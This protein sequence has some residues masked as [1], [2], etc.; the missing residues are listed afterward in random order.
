MSPERATP[1]VYGGPEPIAE[2]GRFSRGAA[3]R[4]DGVRHSSTVTAWMRVESAHGFKLAEVS[5]PRV[6]AALARVDGMS[7]EDLRVLCAR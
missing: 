6:L 4:L 5:D 7:D 2:A 3:A 1:G